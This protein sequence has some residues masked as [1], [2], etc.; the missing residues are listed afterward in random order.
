MLERIMNKK[1]LKQC[2]IISEK[3]NHKHPDQDGYRH[4]SFVVQNEKIIEWATNTIGEPIMF[5]GYP[6]YGKVHAEFNA[7]NKARGIMVRYSRFEVVNIRITKGGLIR[8][9]CPCKNCF[10][11]L[12]SHGCSKIWFTTGLNKAF[13]RV[14][15]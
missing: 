3:N 13:A 11:F 7:L 1:I 8:N 5:L 15:C 4:F 6:S 10:D 9:S 14:E 12:A 2:L